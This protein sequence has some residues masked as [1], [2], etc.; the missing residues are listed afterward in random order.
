D[1]APV[2]AG[3]FLQSIHHV[4]LG[5]VAEISVHNNLVATWQL[6]SRDIHDGVNRLTAD[7]A[8]HLINLCMREV[9]ALVDLR[10]LQVLGIAMCLACARTDAHSKD[11]QCAY[12]LHRPNE[13]E[14]SHGRVSW[15]TR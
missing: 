3:G 7:S 8:N 5:T 6:L 2:S 13:K 12:A 11:G 15:Q 14:I 4:P 1:N 9:D 10:A